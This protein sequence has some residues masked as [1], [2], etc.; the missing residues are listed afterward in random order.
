MNGLY[1]T[2]ILTLYTM[3]DH[4]KNVRV[5]FKLSREAAIKL[6]E[7]ALTKSELLCKLGVLAVQLGNES[8]ICIS[9]ALNFE[10]GVRTKISE[11]GRTQNRC[12]NKEN[13]SL[14]DASNIPKLDNS[15]KT[16]LNV[17]RGVRPVDQALARATADSVLISDS[18]PSVSSLNK[19]PF[20]NK[21]SS[22]EDRATH[23]VQTNS[24]QDSYN[25]ARDLRASIGEN[26]AAKNQP[27]MKPISYNS[28]IK[29]N[30]KDTVSHNIEPHRNSFHAKQSSK[31]KNTNNVLHVKPAVK[32]LG[33]VVICTNNE[34]QD[35]ITICSVDSVSGNTSKYAK[36]MTVCQEPKSKSDLKTHGQET[37]RKAKVFPQDLC[38]DSDGQKFDRTD[39]KMD[40][41]ILT[42]HD[43]MSNLTESFDCSVNN[44]I[45][46]FP[47]HG[48]SFAQHL[49][50]LSKQYRL[51]NDKS[52]TAVANE[53]FFEASRIVRNDHVLRSFTTGNDK[54]E[55]FMDFSGQN[56]LLFDGSYNTT[57][58][59]SAEELSKEQSEASPTNLDSMSEASADSLFEEARLGS[60]DELRYIG[61]IIISSN[62]YTISKI[63]SPAATLPPAYLMH[64]NRCCY[65]F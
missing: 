8:Q 34:I 50:N 37:I 22:Q 59:K 2:L 44:D 1:T 14:K 45:P 23:K 63:T 31:K 52:P 19:A 42:E 62:N 53:K 10:N 55:D 51:E 43:N 60:V 13:G 49:I 16:L 57:T 7:I 41:V 11:T 29:F 36:D 6:R 25:T 58:V 5:S 9:S 15:V 17:D 39:I 65:V 26:S 20:M 4:E 21:T 46:T 40:S 32:N 56:A 33:E 3:S 38:S 54:Q 30:T 24:N 18:L 12:A 64:R 28:V 47:G 27:A 48:I 35:A 61:F